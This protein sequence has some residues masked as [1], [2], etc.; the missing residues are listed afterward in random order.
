MNISLTYHK[1]SILT[2]PHPRRN[3]RYTRIVAID[4]QGFNLAESYSVCHGLIKQNRSLRK[5]VFF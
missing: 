2:P 1:Y 5:P 3:V 4:D